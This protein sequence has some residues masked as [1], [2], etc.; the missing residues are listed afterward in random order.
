[1]MND[2]MTV[3]ELRDILAGYDPETPVYVNDG[4]TLL[5]V[6]DLGSIQ[7][8]FNDGVM[9]ESHHGSVNVIALETS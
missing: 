7:A 4:Y 2:P 9:V 5:P 3:E 8:D 6:T 1:M